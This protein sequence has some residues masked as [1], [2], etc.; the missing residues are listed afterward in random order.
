MGKMTFSKMPEFNR[1]P[2]LSEQLADFLLNEIESGSFKTGDELYSESELAYR[3]NL[4]RATVREA[5][6]RLNHYG[7]IEKSQGSLS[8]IAS[9]GSRKFF[10]LHSPINAD[11]KTICDLYE[12]RASIQSG[13][14]ELAA[15]YRTSDDLTKMKRYLKKMDMALNSEESGTDFNYNFHKAIAI[16]S[17]NP[18]FAGLVEFLSD[19]LWD[20]IQTSLNSNSNTELRVLPEDRSIFEKVSRETQAEHEKMFHAILDRDPKAARD[21]CISHSKNAARRRGLSIFSL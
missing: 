11:I 3:F 17:H 4:S 8:R 2:D 13:I 9:P 20:L 21:A 12:F 6:A 1:A 5:L 19:K 18:F 15:I 16:A 7:V 14:A 10:R